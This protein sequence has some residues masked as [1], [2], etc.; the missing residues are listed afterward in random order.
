METNSAVSVEG[1]VCV[2][3]CVCVCMYN[4]YVFESEDV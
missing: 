4:V 1:S 3:V 2:C